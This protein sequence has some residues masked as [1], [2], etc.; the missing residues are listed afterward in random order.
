MGPLY[1]E[2]PVPEPSSKHKSLHISCLPH[3]QVRPPW[4][5]VP[6]YRAFFYTSRFPNRAPIKERC[7]ISRALLPLSL[8]VPCK[9]MPSP[10]SPMEP[11]QRHPSTA[12]STSH[13]QK[14]HLS[15]R[16][17]SKGAP[18]MFPNRVPMDRDTPSP[19]PLVHS[20]IHV[21]LPESPKR[22]PP[23]CGENHKVTVHGALRGRK[24]YIQ[25]GVAWFPKGIIN[26]TAI[27]TPVP[28]SPRHNTF[29]LG[30][31]RPELC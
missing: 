5:E 14:I 6:I 24:A 18:S 8:T 4:K 7:S 15:L 20:F 26:N 17:T 9:W 27:S 22:S 29:H 19:E 11:L 13:P 23:T 12:P 16:V 2:T 31:G 3:F 10:G 30:L 1:G 28:C 21:C 25:W